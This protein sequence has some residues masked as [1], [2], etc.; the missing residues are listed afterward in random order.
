MHPLLDEMLAAGPVVTDGA[1]GTQLQERGLPQGAVPDGWNLEHPDRVEA[2]ARAY[3][4]AGSRVILTNTFRANRLALASYGLADQVAAIN[5]EGVAISL[6]AARP[7]AHVLAS[8]GPSGRLLFAEQVSESELR[9]AF[10]EQAQTLAAA[11]A[12]G[13]VVETM[14]DLN[15]ARLAVAAAHETGLPVVAC[16]VF[17][18]GK[19]RDRTLTGVTPEQAAGAL[20]AAGADIVGANCGQGIEAFL[21]ICCRLAAESRRPVWIKANAGLPQIEGD[22]IVYRTSPE[23][24]AAYVPALLDAGAGFVG[25]CCGTTPA[26]ITAIGETLQGRR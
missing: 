22:R 25:G 20:L 26:F 5:A 11:G 16:M 13:L 17:D 24:F 7:R 21:P 18:S 8:L 6:R 19:Q 12:D 3:V 10:A 4:E 14:G 15:E 1:W 2:V 23:Q 9:E